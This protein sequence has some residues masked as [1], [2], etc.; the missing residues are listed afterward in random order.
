MLLSRVD[1]ERSL[2]LAPAPRRNQPRWRARA[3]GFAGTPARP[4]SQALAALR[5]RSRSCARRGQSGSILLDRVERRQHRPAVD[6]VPAVAGEPAGGRTPPAQRR[7]GAT[8]LLGQQ[9][10]LGGSGRPNTISRDPVADVAGRVRHLAR[11]HRVDLDQQQ[12]A[13]AAVL[14]QHRERRVGDEA[15]VPIG[16]AVDH[17]RRVHLRQAG[18]RHDHPRSTARRC[19][20]PG[21]ARCA[22]WSRR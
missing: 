10:Q 15:A 22:G 12:V 13:R 4:C 19:R 2:E 3:G 14:D 16:F 20:R 8:A 5:P 21:R 17:H 18:R 11:P 6:H 7:A 1:C 9:R